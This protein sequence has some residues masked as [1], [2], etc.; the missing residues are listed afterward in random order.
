MSKTKISELEKQ[1]GAD[2]KEIISFLKEQGIDVKTANSSVDE[3]VAAMALQKFGKGKT[4]TVPQNENTKETK[5]KAQAV[6]ST[7]AKETVKNTEKPEENKTQ[8]E[9]PKAQAPAAKPAGSA[10]PQAAKHAAAGTQPAKPAGAQAPAG[11]VVARPKKKKIIIVTNGNVG[12]GAHAGAGRRPAPQGQRTGGYSSGQG[13]YGGRR[14]TFQQPEHHIIKPKTVPTQ[15]EVDYHKPDLNRKPAKETITETQEAAQNA[16]QQAAQNEAAAAAKTK[17]SAAENAAAN[18]A[19]AAAEKAAG[20]VSTPAPAAQAPAQNV[21]APA[22]AENGAAASTKENTNASAGTAERPAQSTARETGAGQAQ[23]QDRD[24]RPQASGSYGRQGDGRTERGADTRSGAGYGSR[25]GGAGYGSRPSGTGYGNRQGGTGYGN[26]PSG[27]GYGNRQGGSGYGSRPSGTGYGNR[28]GGTGYGNRPSGSG[29]GGRQGGTGFGGRPGSGF[30]GRPGQGGYGSR[31]GQ[32]GFRPGAGRPAPGGRRDGGN[33]EFVRDAEKHRDADSRKRSLG[34]DKRDRRDYMYNDGGESN[35]AGRFIRPEHKDEAPE[36]KIKTIS[37]PDKI[38]IRDLAEKMHMRDAD[39]IKKLFL[40]GRVTTPNTELTYEEAE[41]I[42]VDYDI[43]CEHEEKVDEIK[44]MLKDEEDVAENM[45]SRA[46]VICVMGHVDHGKTSLL[47]L[48]RT[49]ALTGKDPEEAAAIVQK[50][51]DSRRNSAVENVL[52]ADKEAGGIT[53]AIGAYV[54]NVGSG[55]DARKIT[56][57]DTPGHEAFTAMR[58]RG[59][60]STDIAVLVVAADDGVMPQTVEAIHHAKAAGIEI[61]VAVNKIDKPNAD[62]NLVK[63][64]LTKYE[65]VATD[66]GGSTEV[67]PVSAKTGEGISDLL[68]TILLTADVLELKADPKR[69]ARGLVLEAKLD[70]GRGPVANV[71]VQ[72]GT[73][74]VGD[75]ISAGAAS[76]KVRAMVDDR[77]K[78]VKEAGPSVPVEVLGLSEAPNAGEILVAHD[79]DKEAKDFAETFRNQHKEDLLEE[80][81]MSM[82]LDDL[83]SQMKEGKLKE[84]DIIIKADVQGSVEALKQSLVKLSNDEIIVKC[85]HSGA[86]SITESD[87]TLAS[88]SNAVIIGFGVRPDPVA[89]SLADRAGVDI[90]LYSVIYE[91]IDAVEAA[92]KGMEA[93]VY[94]ENVTGHAE[95]R[96]I[97][98]ASKVGNI[99]GSSVTDGVIRKDSKIRITRGGEQIYEGALASLKRFK[100]DVKEV[101]EGFECGLVFEEFD[102]FEVGDLVEAYEMVKVTGDEAAKIKAERAAAAKA[103]AAKAKA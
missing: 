44:E 47:D 45:V 63:Q 58:M 31:P 22:P 83:Y 5:D 102:Q 34:R 20:A 82:S 64:E 13:S 4:N 95:I 75:F 57:L 29:Y 11:G 51:K 36:E 67:I 46:P 86:G 70:K 66:W 99:A 87:V 91:A 93:P 101:K 53:Q 72:K 55:K 79:S 23:R 26:R 50:N 94:K 37:V 24:R 84:F 68:D 38:T 42:A 65:L 74:H 81:R 15:M 98:K 88:A 90:E 48:I 10:A 1:T 71:L 16:A 27:T 56:F 62:V 78:R 77:G 52:V 41:N 40:A 59:A 18:A 76:G 103:D 80:N 7:A 60:K 30:G 43:L 21:Q 49:M 17:A 25:Q 73:L 8:A 3:S 97:F 96:Q 28:Q 69:S 35:R 39:I 32:G 89:K 12:G 9:K 61:I 54:V 85:I 92:I 6:K 2:R 100:D 14:G 33:T 19:G